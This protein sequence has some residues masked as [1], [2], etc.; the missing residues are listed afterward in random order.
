MYRKHFDLLLVLLLTV[1]GAVI[2]VTSTGG[3]IRV[4]LTLPLV[5]VLPGYAL[6]EA[7]FAKPNM[8]FP[9]K[10]AFILGL[11]LAVDILGGLVLNLTPWGLQTSSWVILLSGFTF[12]AVGVAIWRRKHIPAV[13]QMKPHLD[14]RQG[15]LF[16]LA[17]VI[18]GGALAVASLGVLN[19]PSQRFTQFW[20][21]PVKDA[22]VDTVQVGISNMET[23][24]ISYKVELKIGKKVIRDWSPIE[25]K[26]GENWTVEFALPKKQ[27]EVEM[28]EALLYRLDSPDT[29]YR[30]VTL[31]R[32]Q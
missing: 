22:N 17:A 9:E 7:I 24:D 4:L 1:L 32:V 11:S 14:I 15:V 20:I 25:L 2:A 21:L 18:A 6:T 5:F 30:R 26:R 31:W 16:G 10:V 19:Q 8:E 23:T 27:T 3:F 29:I 12:G 13:Q 28:V